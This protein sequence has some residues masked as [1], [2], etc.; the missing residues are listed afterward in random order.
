MKN[1]PA[2]IAASIIPP[3]EIVTEVVKRKS[4][5]EI[6]PASRAESG[7]D[8]VKVGR[9][10]YH[11]KPDP[12]TWTATDLQWYVKNLYNDKYGVTLHIPVASG[13]N[14]IK[15][16]KFAMFKKLGHDPSHSLM[17][18]FF[19][20]CFQRHVDDIIRSEG[21]FTLYKLT[22]PKYVMDFFE[23]RASTRVSSNFI[24]EKQKPVETSSNTSAVSIDDLTAAY[25][26]N[27]QYMVSTYG[28]V[29]TINFLM[30]VKGK[31]LDESVS[32]VQSAMVKLSAKGQHEMQSAIDATNKYQ[33]YPKWLTFTDVNRIV[34]MTIAISDDNPVLNVFKE[35]K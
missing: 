27:P 16:I 32:Y 29:V 21:S 6:L 28:I 31:T 2:D 9:E 23:G 24:V 4:T 5:V 3:Q 10:T 7:W 8:K 11:S 17:K 19:D 33:P 15:T 13:H 30:K 26:I 1:N 12:N 34:K 22:K 25:R 14:W 35:L 18:E 20:F